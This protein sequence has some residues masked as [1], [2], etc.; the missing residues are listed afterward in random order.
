MR[1]PVACVD[2]CVRA[3]V[4]ACVCVC[5]CAQLNVL[6]IVTHFLGGVYVSWFITNSWAF[7]KMWCVH[8]CVHACLCVCACLRAGVHACVCVCA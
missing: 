2:A 4:C 8:V 3:C 1:R 7:D 5:V 6:Q